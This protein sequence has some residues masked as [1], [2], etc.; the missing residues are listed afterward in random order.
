MVCKLRALQPKFLGIGAKVLSP[1]FSLPRPL[2]ARR[3]A[4]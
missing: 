4:A 1:N 3:E 2:K